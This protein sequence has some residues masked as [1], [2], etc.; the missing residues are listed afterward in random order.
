MEARY[1]RELKRKKQKDLMIRLIIIVLILVIVLFAFLYP[2]ISIQTKTIEITHK[3]IPSEFIDYKIMQISDLY[4]SPN[5]NLD[6]FAERVNK[7]EPNIIVFTGNTF[8][9]DDENFYENF[10]SFKEKINTNIL[11][12][13]SLGE[14]ELNLPED[15]RNQLFSKL[16]QKGIYTL[17]D[18]KISLVHGGKIINL[19]G[20]TP[21]LSDYS[22]DSD[23][24]NLGKKVDIKD[25]DFTIA[26]SNNPGYFPELSI[27]DIDLVLSGA[28]SG[29]W[30][31]IPFLGGIK[32]DVD[33]L[34]KEGQY[35]AMESRMII[36]NG[37][38]TRQGNIRIL[39]PRQINEIIL[40]R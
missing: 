22:L 40:K 5:D 6:K 39:N 28:R 18:R 32:Y 16:S 27:N 10:F 4:L 1:N 26:L 33:S 29:G 9:M 8:E 13:V 37:A 24:L 36:S 38:G 31:R 23:N 3:D 17:D 15:Y 30:V 11:I 19:L 34:Y 25:E 12:Y 14:T 2:M 20:I 21:N 7:S 35:E